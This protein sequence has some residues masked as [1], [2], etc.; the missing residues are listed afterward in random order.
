MR[1]NVYIT[2]TNNTLNTHHHIVVRPSH[3]YHEIQVFNIYIVD[4]GFYL[5]HVGPKFSVVR[6]IIL[7]LFETARGRHRS[8]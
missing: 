4:I 1:F 3:V 2:S 8:S 6:S 7:R 5:E